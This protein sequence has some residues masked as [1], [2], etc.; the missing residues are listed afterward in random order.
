MPDFTVARRGTDSSGR[1]I[2][3]TAFFW[4]VWQA[5]LSDPRVEPFAHL[6]TVVQGAFMARLGGGAVA[7]AGYHDLAGCWDVRTW[8]LTLRQQFIL[9]TVAWE[10]GLCFWKRDMAHG[11]MDEHGHAIGGW[12]KPLAGG[13]AYQWTQAQ[14]GR[15]GF[16]SNGPD[17]MKRPDTPLPKFP[18]A[19]LL[20]EDYLMTD[21]AR[22]QLNE[23]DNKLDRLLGRVNDTASAERERDRAAA[24]KAKESKRQLV[25]TLGGVAD[26]LGAIAESV[27]DDATKGQLRA[28]KNIVLAALAA[29]PDVDGPDNPAIEG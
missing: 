7:S 29:D 6:V 1:P 21:T 4:R 27:E 28:V 10:Y 8:N 19:H 22:A 25:S 14:N 16:A 3:A 23:I 5:I 13:A 11:G 2:L 26:Q 20:R 17:Y 24:K 18:P 9:W 12:D 15:D